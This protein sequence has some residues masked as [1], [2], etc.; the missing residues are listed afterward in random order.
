MFADSSR[1]P[2]A[3]PEAVTMSRCFRWLSSR[4]GLGGP[5][6]WER[7]R[8]GRLLCLRK[9]S[10]FSRQV[11]QSIF[12]PSLEL[13]KRE[14]DSGKFEANKAEMDDP[15]NNATIEGDCVARPFPSL[16]RF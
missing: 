14:T 2:A 9:A 12:M 15:I 10:F 8:E 1:Q 11:A 5:G 13:R 7:R 16:I 6:A 3:F 4:A